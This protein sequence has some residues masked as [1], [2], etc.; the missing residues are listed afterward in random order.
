LK[1]IPIPFKS[2]FYYIRIY[3]IVWIDVRE[4]CRPDHIFGLNVVG[5]LVDPRVDGE[6][7]SGLAFVQHEVRCQQHEQAELVALAFEAAMS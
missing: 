4:D 1:K 5:E 6:A 2:F 3:Q 7:V